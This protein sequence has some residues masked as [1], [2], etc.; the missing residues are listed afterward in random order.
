MTIRYPVV[1]NVM[2]LSLNMSIARIISQSIFDYP[3]LSG[4]INKY[5]VN[6]PLILSIYLALYTYLTL[7]ASSV[8][9][10]DHLYIHY[11]RLITL[12]HHCKQLITGK[13]H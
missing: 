13:E 5:I 1:I 6:P 9:R 2:T 11:A 8:K 4:D 12:Y 7:K 10:V 3:M